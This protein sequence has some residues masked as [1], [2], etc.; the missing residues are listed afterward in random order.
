MIVGS[1][2]ASSSR[3]EAM[4]DNVVANATSPLSIS[5]FAECLIEIK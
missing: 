4:E 3:L 2:S 5:P 1:S